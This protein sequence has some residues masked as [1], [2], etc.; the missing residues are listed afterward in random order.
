MTPD[1]AAPIASV[2]L[3]RSR[4]STLRRSSASGCGRPATD[5]VPARSRGRRRSQAAVLQ[6]A[7]ARVRPGGGGGPTGTVVGGPNGIVMPGATS[8]VGWITVSDG[9]GGAVVAGGGG[10]ACGTPA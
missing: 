1:S 2:R 6:A 4:S 10:G 3:G 9:G 7:L 8:I 5:N